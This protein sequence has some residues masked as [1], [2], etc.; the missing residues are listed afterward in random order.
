VAGEAAG[1]EP[2][3]AFMR[4]STDAASSDWPAALGAAGVVAL[5]G[6]AAAGAGAAAGFDT[7]GAGAEAEAAAAIARYLAIS[8]SADMPL[9]TGEGAAAGVYDAGG[10]EGD[11]PPIALMRASTDAASSDWLEDFGAAGAGA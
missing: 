8:S 2:S 5:R 3:I 4:A 11:D 9:L 6:G 7:A 1:A 10:V